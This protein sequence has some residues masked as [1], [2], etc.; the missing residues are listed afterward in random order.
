M[1]AKLA[2][3]ML[4]AL[5]LTTNGANAYQSKAQGYQPY[6]NPDRETYVNRSCCAWKS[7]HKVHKPIQH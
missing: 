4:G 3:I 6:P 7:S 1:K 5:V 2:M